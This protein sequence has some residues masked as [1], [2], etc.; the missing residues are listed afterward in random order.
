MKTF[1]NLK[2]VSRFD[3]KV[4]FNL[5]F[6]TALLIGVSA[7]DC[8]AQSL[9]LKKQQK[10]IDATIDDYK[11]EIVEK[12]GEFDF[13]LSVDYKAFEAITDKMG[14]IPTQ[15]F[16]QVSN[17]LRA[18]CSSSTATGEQDADGAAAVKSKI[19]SIVITHIADPKKKT[20]TLKDG[21]LTV[22]NSFGT[23]SGVLDYVKIREML[24]KL[25]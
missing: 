3:A 1:T 2:L 22:Q 10:E 25:L 19:K 6:L 14:L 17:A 20:L 13:E 8:S 18:I 23:P 9:A 24:S 16:K 5:M 11:K 15:G 7:F 21:V 4:L 12:C